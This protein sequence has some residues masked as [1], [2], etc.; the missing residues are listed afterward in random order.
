MS[1]WVFM[2]CHFKES[3]SRI[4]IFLSEETPF[5][6]G[7]VVQEKTEE[8]KTVASPFQNGMEYTKVY[9]VPFSHNCLPTT[10][11]KNKIKHIYNNNYLHHTVS[12]TW[13][14]SKPNTKHEYN[15]SSSNF[16]LSITRLFL[17]SI[18]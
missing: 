8:V 1:K 2:L 10:K 17:P 11:T 12:E 3:S 13:T 5:S 18:R 9:A 14:S 7:L 4:N 15:D 16:T 6:K